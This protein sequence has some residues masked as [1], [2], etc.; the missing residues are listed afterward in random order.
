MNRR[1]I[2]AVVGAVAVVAL[3]AGAVMAQT[4]GG[5]ATSNAF[6]DRVAQKL[7]I[8]S[9]KL[10]DAITSVR[11]EDIDAKVQSGDLTQ[12]QADA[13]KLRA[14][15]NPPPL[16]PALRTGGGRLECGAPAIEP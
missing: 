12:K 15:N 14:A 9:P 11:N 8:E 3:G 16:R 4:G 7:G 2:A 6:L 13:L 5:N 10:Q 1:W